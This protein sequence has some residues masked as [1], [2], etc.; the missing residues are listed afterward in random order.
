MIG[1]ANAAGR[2][3]TTCLDITVRGTVRGEHEARLVVAGEPAA[4]DLRDT[5]IDIA[6]AIGVRPSERGSTG[7]RGDGAVAYVPSDGFAGTE[8]F[9]VTTEDAAGGI[10]EIG[11][12]V[13]K[14]CEGASAPTEIPEPVPPPPPFPRP[15][16]LVP[17]PLSPIGFAELPDPRRVVRVHDRSEPRGARG[18]ARRDAPLRGLHSRR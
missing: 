17:D 14:A 11:V 10:R 4:H 15:R 12:E 1:L 16:P 13:E 18:E 6:H 3:E 9:A 5:G 8:T 7:L 2:M